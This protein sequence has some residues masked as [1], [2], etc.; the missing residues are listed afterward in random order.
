MKIEIDKF[1]ENTAVKVGK[2]ILYYKKN[3]LIKVVKNQKNLKTNIDLIAN[4]IWVKSIKK[5]FLDINILS[6]EIKIKKKI[7]KNWT[8][9]IIDPIDGTR[10]LRDN[11]NSYVTQVAFIKNGEIIHSIIYNPETKEIF[12]KNSK[13]KKYNSKINSIID[14]YPKPNKKLAQII[15]KL[16]I[17]NYIEAGSIGYKISKVLDNTSDLF[18]K[19]NK[20]KL[21]DVAPAILLIKK[22]GGSIT[23]KYFQEISLNQIDVHGLVVTMNKKNFNFIKKKFPKGLLV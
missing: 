11:Y 21:W 2:K 8:G 17:P 23:N 19:L 7:K 20:I 9:F 3:N 6:E 5:K 18:I 13:F 15:K 16:K 10:S 4:D 22:N 1:L 12:S 14:N